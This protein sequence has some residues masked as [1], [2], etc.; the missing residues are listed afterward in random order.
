MLA[1]GQRAASPSA[2]DDAAGGQRHGV[3]VERLAPGA[4]RNARGAQRER[5]A[6]RPAQVV[7]LGQLARVQ[8][9]QRARPGEQC[10]LQ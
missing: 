6:E 4:G 7:A 3:L 9:Q 2:R 1:A 8:R 5:A 10:H